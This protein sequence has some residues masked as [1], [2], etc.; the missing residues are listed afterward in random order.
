M[1]FLSGGESGWPRREKNEEERSWWRHKTGLVTILGVQP[2]SHVRI[3][4]YHLW[5]VLEFAS[6]AKGPTSN[7]IG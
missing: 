7:P 5:Y 1:S 2:V 6:D 3:M 4:P